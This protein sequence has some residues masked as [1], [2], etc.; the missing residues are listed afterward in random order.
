MA[1]NFEDLQDNFI[2]KCVGNCCHCYCKSGKIGKMSWTF[3]VQQENIFTY[4]I[5]FFQQEK[6]FCWDNGTVILWQKQW[7]NRQFVV[8]G[9][10]KSRWRIHTAGCHAAKTPQ[11]SAIRRRL[12]KEEATPHHR[13]AVFLVTCLKII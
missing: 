8:A 13:S 11:T 7:L 4:I 1:W 12:M 6:Y 3:W 10:V 5:F 9:M 2:L